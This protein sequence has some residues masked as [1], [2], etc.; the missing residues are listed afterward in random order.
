[1]KFFHKAKDGG[2]LSKVT[3]FWLVEL[4]RLFSIALLKFEHGSRDEYHSHAFN[5]VSWVLRGSLREEHIFGDIEKHRPSVFPIR[6]YR[7]TFHR[8]YSVGTTW[9]LTFRGPWSKQWAEFNPETRKYTTLE[10][11]RVVAKERVLG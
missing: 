6:T 8:V 10:N 7:H 2:P 9:V 11:G 3:G 1:M 4:K 5:S